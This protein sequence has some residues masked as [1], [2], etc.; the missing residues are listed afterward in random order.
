MIKLRIGVFCCQTLILCQYFTN[1][2]ENTEPRQKFSCGSCDPITRQWWEFKT[3]TISVEA[4][5]QALVL[6]FGVSCVALAEEQQ[7]HG[8][9][10]AVVCKP[11]KPMNKIQVIKKLSDL[12]NYIAFLGLLVI[13]LVYLDPKKDPSSS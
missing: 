11:W 13:S 3:E 6:R 10:K 8:C 2:H 12:E 9:D 1:T 5:H 4:A 7:T